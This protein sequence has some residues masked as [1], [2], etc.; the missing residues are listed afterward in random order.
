MARDALGHFLP[1]ESGNP[2]GAP[3]GTKQKMTK[4][5]EM[6]LDAFLTMY[7]DGEGADPDAR[8]RLMAIAIMKPYDFLKIV[9]SLLPNNLVIEGDV[10][11]Q[12]IQII[13]FGEVNPND[14]RTDTK[15]PA[16]DESV[17]AANSKA[18]G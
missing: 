10:G 5:R 15:V 9:A 2:D 7:G 16:G 1:G 12:R 4:V 14:K 8:K 13:K 11:G 17:A 6:I 3:K 18:K